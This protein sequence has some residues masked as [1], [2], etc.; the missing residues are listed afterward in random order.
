MRYYEFQADRDGVITFDI[1]KLT[2]RYKIQQTFKPKSPTLLLD[3]TI[4][5]LNK[6]LQIVVNRDVIGQYMLFVQN[7]QA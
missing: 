3:N 7:S 5:I 1:L 2:I 6:C 4:S